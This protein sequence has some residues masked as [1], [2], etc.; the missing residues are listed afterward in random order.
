MYT[1]H[2]ASN[3]HKLKLSRS[4]AALTENPSMAV[5]SSK[6]VNGKSKH[7]NSSLNKLFS[8]RISKKSQ[9]SNNLFSPRIIK[10]NEKSK[11]KEKI[12]Y[13]PIK[14]KS[15]D[16]KKN[17]QSTQYKSLKILSKGKSP[18]NQLNTSKKT[19]ISTTIN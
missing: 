9:I 6:G 13:K 4:S 16:Q 19:I 8:P 15:K 11:S 7:K 14:A 5:I 18:S 2:S 10:K 3:S 12:L 17:L 1:Q